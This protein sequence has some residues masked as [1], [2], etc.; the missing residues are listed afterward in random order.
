MLFR[1]IFYLVIAYTAL[2]IVRWLIKPTTRGARRMA[3]GRPRPSQMIRCATCGM[4]ITQTS[5]LALGGREFCSKSCAERRV[6]SA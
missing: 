1:F 6:H 3:A 5:A 2:R 4:F